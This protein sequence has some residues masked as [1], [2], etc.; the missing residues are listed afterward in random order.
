MNTLLQLILHEYRKY[1]FTRGFLLFLLII[2]I[3]GAFGFVASQISEKAAPIRSFAVVDEAGSY[4]DAID[5]ALE[6][7]RAER[8]LALWDAYA[9][10]AV[11]TEAGAFPLPPPYAPAPRT[12][13][14]RRAFGEQGG[15]V[16]ALAAAQPYLLAE[17]PPPPVSRPRFVR[18]PTPA[19]VESFSGDDRDEVLRAYVRGDRA[20]PDNEPAP[21][22]AIVIPESVDSGGVVR[23]YTN[24]LLDRDLRGFVDRAITEAVKAQSFEARGVDPS[25]V[26]Q[27]NDI[28]VP[29]RLF[30]ASTET[31]DAAGG[32]EWAETVIPLFL[33]YALFVMVMS[34]GGMLLTST[35]EEK[36]NKIVEVLLSSVSAGQLMASK[37]IGLALVG[38]T[39]PAIF[40]TAG[41]VSTE[42]LASQAT[43]GSDVATSVAAIKSALF[44]SRLIPLFFFYFLIGYLL[45]ASIY[46]AV[47][48]M[49]NTIQDA[50]SF[51]GP[52]TILLVLPF[53]FLQLVVQDPNGL[54]ARVLT[55]IPIYTPYAIMIRMS[56]NPPQWEIIAATA[57]LLVIVAFVVTA[58]GRIYRNGVLSSG[59][60]PSLKQAR[61]LARSRR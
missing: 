30:K 57:M 26:A 10:V 20:M 58:M 2:P 44:A 29:V 16:A 27:V 28:S 31:G 40:L 19:E 43:S 11:R 56:A 54:I 34:I 36:S 13:E 4:I 37:L 18:L 6:D 33:A 53:P 52:L 50:Q 1:V 22:A 25:I 45:F 38:M 59:G 5:R 48:A 61:A 15:L 55:W 8:D 23:F 14:R 49:S 7:D 46:L 17:A 3:S 41:F 60:A 12:R 24:N 35:V 39:I 9:S 47:G 51:V 21:F 32:A 42:I